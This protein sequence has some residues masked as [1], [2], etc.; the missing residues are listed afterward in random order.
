MQNVP[1]K[2]SIML[3]FDSMK[4]PNSGFFSFGKSLGEAVISQNNGR[5]NLYYYVHTRA[6]Y[7]F[8]KKVS[9]VFLSKIHKLFFPEPKRFALVHFTD[10]YCRLRPKKIIGKKILTIHDINPVH[11]KNKPAQ[12]IAKHIEKLRAYI[13]S[14]DRIV[15][16][17]H[18]V[19]NDILKYFPEAKE[20]LSVIYNG[21]DQ[22]IVPEGH[23]P[24]YK[25]QEAFLFT[26]GHVSAKKNFHVLP[27]LLAGNDYELIISGIETIYK[28]QIMEE[29]LKYGVQ[30]RVKITGPVSEDD[31]AW[32]YKNCAAFVFPSI[33][34]G[35]G[36]PVIEAMH[37]GKPVF[38]STH[39]SL[40]EIG[41]DAAFYFERFEPTLMQKTFAGGMALFDTAM[42]EKVIAHAQKFDWQQTATAYL[43]LYEELIG[44]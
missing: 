34:E 18:F 4:Y 38:L 32:Y 42:E 44:S 30:D 2:P 11:E 21:A 35:F 33:A 22:L 26:I 9:L 37:F 16:I 31:K 3:T 43:A 24:L 29:A 28:D 15:T 20:K 13:A 12:K 14:C 19:A 25:P 27:A 40:P 17:S 7:L 39:T 5:F 10:Q 6:S 41:G 36:L 8:K 23:S 1:A